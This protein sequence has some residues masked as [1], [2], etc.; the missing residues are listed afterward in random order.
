MGFNPNLHIE[1]RY[2]LRIIDDISIVNEYPNISPELLNNKFTID[3]PNGDKFVKTIPT[4]CYDREELLAIINK[5]IDN[6]DIT[7]IGESRSMFSV[8]IKGEYKI[9][10]RE[11][12]A[13]LLGVSFRVE[14]S[15]QFL[16]NI[17]DFK[18][19]NR[20]VVVNDP[21]SKY[22]EFLEC[23]LYNYEHEPHKLI[24]VSPLCNYMTPCVINKMTTLQFQI[25][26]T[27]TKQLVPPPVGTVIKVSFYTGTC[28]Y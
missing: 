6:P 14:K 4:G 19:L 28:G 16:F 7:L 5:L 27:P 26:L 15:T 8:N 10:F 25:L 23:S 21:I 13:Y 20:F 2:I 1:S 9:A 18:V 22:S 12:L 3:Y 24:M 17:D 11:Q